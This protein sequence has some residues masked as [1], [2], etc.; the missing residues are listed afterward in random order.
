MSA[1]SGYNLS[2]FIRSDTGVENVD[3]FFGD[4]GYFLRVHLPPNPQ[5][6]PPM[7]QE[8][9]FLATSG[10]RFEAGVLAG[11]G[12]FRP[13]SIN[14]RYSVSSGIIGWAPNANEVC[15]TCNFMIIQHGIGENRIEDKIIFNLNP[16]SA[17]KPN[18]SLTGTAFSTH[19]GHN[20]PFTGQIF[21]QRH[22]VVRAGQR[23]NWS[24]FINNRAGA[25]GGDVIMGYCGVSVSYVGPGESALRTF[26]GANEPKFDA[27]S[28]AGKDR[29]NARSIDLPP[30]LQRGSITFSRE[31]RRACTGHN[32]ILM[33]TRISGRII[34]DKVII[35]IGD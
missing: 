33:T 10:A 28:L 18:E 2:D 25:V 8:A 1:G 11:R 7:I 30:T 13:L 15:D 3:A 20:I 23:Y 19:P 6:R 24:H 32:F 35:Y 31:S 17:R 4:C 27:G 29:F 22:I 9:E 14:L 34:R 12:T 26:T 5:G 16:I 21:R